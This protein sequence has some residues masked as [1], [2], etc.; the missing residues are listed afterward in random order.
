[1]RTRASV[2]SVFTLKRVGVAVAGLGLA[3][4]LGAGIASPAFADTTTGTTGT[5]TQQ[6]QQSGVKPNGNGP[7][8]LGVLGDC[9]SPTPTP[10]D[11]PTGGPTGQPTGEP[12]GQPT[13]QPT[14]PT[15]APSPIGQGGGTNGGG[16]IANSGS[17]SPSAEAVT[18]SETL[19]VTGASTG[20]IAG[21]G[22]ALAGGGAALLLF[23]RRRR[24]LSAA[25]VRSTDAD[26]E[27]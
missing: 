1:M 15:G 17:Q 18:S 14:Q 4:M 16:L 10:T 20:L 21:M 8:L 12:T 24:A 6:G 22:A 11:T 2:T 26:S 19:P 23:S 9:D 5:Q 7:C 27:D 25:P 3:T 13:G